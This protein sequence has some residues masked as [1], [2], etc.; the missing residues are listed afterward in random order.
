[1]GNC[2]QPQQ[3]NEEGL[4]QVQNQN[5]INGKPERQQYDSLLKEIMELHL[6]SGIQ[7][8]IFL[9]TKVPI[10]GPYS[11]TYKLDYGRIQSKWTE[12][13]QKDV[14]KSKA[15]TVEYTYG[16]S[17]Q[18]VNNFINTLEQ[19]NQ[20]SFLQLI[21]EIQASPSEL[22]K[23]KRSFNQ[24]LPANLMK[25]QV[26]FDLHQCFTQNSPVQPSRVIHESINF[27]DIDLRMMVKEK[28]QDKLQKIRFTAALK[29]KQLKP[30]Q[31]TQLSLKIFEFMYDSKKQVLD[32]NDNGILDEKHGI[33]KFPSVQFTTDILEEGPAINKTIIVQVVEK[34]TEIEKK[35]RE[36][37]KKERIFGE[38]KVK[39]RDLFEKGR[40]HAIMAVDFSLANLTFDENQYCIHTLKE[41]ANNDYIVALRRIGRCFKYFS[42]FMLSYGFGARTVI[43]P[44]ESNACNLFSMTGDFMDPF[45]EDDEELYNSYV[46]TIKSVQLAL[47]VCFKDILKLVCDI[48]QM[49]FGTA[50]DIKQIK[51]YFVVTILMAGVI[52]DFE[53]SLNQILR[54]AHLPVSVIVIKVGAVSEENDST[55][56]M[57]LASKAFSECERKF[58]DI[59]SFENYKKKGVSTQML[60][61]VFEYDLIKNIPKQVEKFFEL[62][63][64]D[65]EAQLETTST[66]ANLETSLTTGVI[67]TR[68]TS[69][70]QT[71]QTTDPL[72]TMPSLYQKQQPRFLEDLQNLERDSFVMHEETPKQFQKNNLENQE[73]KET[74]LQQSPGDE[75]KRVSSSP[76]IMVGLNPTGQCG[77][78]E[79]FDYTK[80]I[81]LFIEQ[82]KLRMICQAQ[83]HG[84]EESTIDQLLQ[85]Q[86]VNDFFIENIKARLGIVDKKPERVKKP[87]NK[88]SPKQEEQKEPLIQEPQIDQQNEVLVDQ[89][90]VEDL[91]DVNKLQLQSIIEQDQSISKKDDE[92]SNQSQNSGDVLE[93]LQTEDSNI[94][95]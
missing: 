11:L 46:G 68:K 60:G 5:I 42:K 39:L 29:P 47:P 21:V 94:Q 44:G 13:I 81:K 27:S 32:L 37:I 45:V 10:K 48:A 25:V 54:A 78:I 63:Q 7:L 14:H 79:N 8:D 57:N 43:Q 55:N 69:M 91:V 67:S 33:Y 85:E 26:V 53:E 76:M 16:L 58:I 73:A 30:L 86:N 6:K 23:V 71:Y 65:L 1:M 34:Y 49:E 3:N 19:N 52:D 41:G 59:L 84:I 18:E 77:L 51:N 35:T 2:A 62:Q 95:L 22:A 56:L 93:N 70:G 28:K 74:L 88:P 38:V 72:E 20:V 17:K 12:Q 36:F 31:N 82:E 15:L 83:K 9:Y 4:K 61:S 64:F 90:K 50:S 80:N 24:Q 75:P 87:V 66:Q 89:P 40:N 92:K